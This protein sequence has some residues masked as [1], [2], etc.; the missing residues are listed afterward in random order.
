MLEPVYL[1]C[2]HL[3]V[4]LDA[5]RQNR[6]V[7]FRYRSY[8]TPDK[9][10]LFTLIPGFVRLFEHRWYLVSQFTLYRRMDNL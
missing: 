8:Y 4:L 1:G 6:V 10:K 5:I 9:D 3:N 7:S 2:E